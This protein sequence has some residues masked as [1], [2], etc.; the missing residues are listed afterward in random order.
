VRD[1]EKAQCIALHALDLMEEGP[2]LAL[3]VRKAFLAGAQVYLVDGDPIPA[4]KKLPFDFN[5]VDSLDGVPFEG[6]GKGVIICGAGKKEP[7]LLAQFASSGAKLVMLQTGPNGMGAGL[8]ALEQHAVPLAE[9]VADGK[10]QAVVCIEAEIPELLLSGLEVLAS[11]DWRSDAAARKAPI[12]LP[13][14]TWVESDGTSIN[15]EGRAQ[16]FQRTRT[17]GIPLKGL[18]SKYYGSATEAVALHPPRVHRSEVPGGAE[19]DAWRVMAQLIERL[20]GEPVVEP[21]SGKWRALKELDPEGEG[22]RVF[23]FLPGE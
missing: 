5:V 1:I 4:G 12:F 11:A 2:M 21:L 13:T 23:A 17:A 10:V 19:R 20:G 22:V 9:L 7:E 8:L 15:C 16:R 14:T 18:D 3:A 6:G